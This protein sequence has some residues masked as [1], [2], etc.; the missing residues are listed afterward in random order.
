MLTPEILVPLT[1]LF[2]LGVYYATFAEQIRN[3]QV[4]ALSSRWYVLGIRIMGIWIMLLAAGV[5]YV[6]ASHHVFNIPFLILKS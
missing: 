3:W 6:L 2:A 1:L 4:R 5:A